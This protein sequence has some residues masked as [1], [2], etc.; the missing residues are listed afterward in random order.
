MSQ[1]DNYLEVEVKFY[2]PD[3]TAVRDKL[4][5]LGGTVT[6]PRLY[7]RNIRFDTP[8]DALLTRR[9]LLRLRQDGSTKITFKGE[10]ATAVQSE[11]KVREEL[12]VE[13]NDFQTAALIFERLGFAPV[14]IY[15]KYRETIQLDAV[16]VMLDEMPFGHFIELEG[17]EAAIKAV[18]ARLGLA[19]SSRIL[20]NYLGLMAQLQAHHQLPFHDLTFA[21]FAG[22][23]VSISD[24][25][26]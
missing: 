19:W 26:P 20:T 14:Q 5:A 25:L 22:K 11:A 7:E 2:V 3:L 13:V 10:P 12:E 17:D 6:K 1:A 16:E 23:S 24:I 4:L 21:N 18:A 9:Q 15:E 8:E